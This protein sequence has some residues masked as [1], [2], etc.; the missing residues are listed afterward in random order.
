MRRENVDN[1]FRFVLGPVAKDLTLGA[2]P[3][4][5]SP[6]P[7]HLDAGI[8]KLATENA[9]LRAVNDELK[10][11]LDRLDGRFGAFLDQHNLATRNEIMMLGQIVRELHVFRKIMIVS[12]AA[13]NPEAERLMDKALPIIMELRGTLLAWRAREGIDVPEYDHGKEADLHERLIH[14]FGGDK[15]TASAAKEIDAPTISREQE[16]ER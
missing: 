8:V 7:D 15:P 10:A 13:S 5:A 11:A 9:A 4:E 12:S 1:K 6:S 2:C 3:Q 14:N 16:R